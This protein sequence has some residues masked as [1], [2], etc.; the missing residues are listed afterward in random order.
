MKLP[1]LRELR[2]RA[3]LTQEELAARTGYS[4]DGLSKLERGK[5]SARPST[6]R[7][8]AEALNVTPEELAAPVAEARAAAFA[9]NETVELADEGFSGVR[10]AAR[11]NPQRT[12][13]Q[14]RRDLHNA[15]SRYLAAPDDED[16]RWI[17]ES[18]QNR[19]GSALEAA[20]R[21]VGDA[22]AEVGAVYLDVIAQHAER[23][24][25]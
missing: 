10:E 12:L 11:R 7:R 1:R 9:P 21:P 15:L 20:G 17:A 18:L 6:V 8:L 23:N 19:Y 13:D 3:V 2:E 4:V 14:T 16:A 25:E 22:V 24:T 5:R